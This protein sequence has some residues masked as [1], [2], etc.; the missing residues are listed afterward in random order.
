MGQTDGQTDNSHQCIMPHPIGCGSVVNAIHQAHHVLTPTVT[1]MSQELVLVDGMSS[2]QSNS[3]AYIAKVMLAYLSLIKALQFAEVSQSGH[4][5]DINSTL[6]L[7]Y[8]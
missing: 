7:H 4:N 8:Y 2:S 6:M 1:H 3:Y 5:T